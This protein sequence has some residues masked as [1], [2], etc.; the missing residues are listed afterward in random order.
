MGGLCFMVN[1][2]MLCG[3]HID[4]KYNDKL[5]LARIGEEAAQLAHSED[6][7][8]PMHSTGRP[9]KGYVFIPSKGLDVDRPLEKWILLC[10]EML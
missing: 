7:V 1:D 8:F 9:M 10:L 6:F 4:K 2:K 5:L 3:I